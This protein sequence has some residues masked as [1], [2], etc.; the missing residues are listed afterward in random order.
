MAE[1]QIVIEPTRWDNA[2]TVNSDTVQIHC[3]LPTGITPQ[4]L[5]SYAR[6]RRIQVTA[7]L[8]EQDILRHF[9][10]GLHTPLEECTRTY[11]AP[12]GSTW[13]LRMG[14]MSTEISAEEAA[15]VCACVDIVGQAYLDALQ[16]ASSLLDVWSYPPIEV[17]GSRGVFLLAVS[18]GLWHLMRQFSDTFP[19]Q[20]GESS[21]HIFEN[22]AEDLRICCTRSCIN[23]TIRPVFSHPSLPFG[24]VGLMYMYPDRYLAHAEQAQETPW[25]EQIGRAH[26]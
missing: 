19:K 26:V 14:S 23:A 3:H 18:A 4:A 24:S 17:D 7:N 6:F 22:T 5:G 21:W 12:S 25:K 10:I 2:L 20:Y 16:E 15:D 9:L 8:T 1:A 11:I 13:L